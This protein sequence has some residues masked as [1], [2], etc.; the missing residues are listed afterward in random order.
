MKVFKGQGHPLFYFL[1]GERVK[2]VREV[3]KGQVDKSGELEKAKR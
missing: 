2:N 1:V 3:S